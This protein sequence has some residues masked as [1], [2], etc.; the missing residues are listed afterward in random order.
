MNKVSL[1]IESEVS[2]EELEE[3]LEALKPIIKMVCPC[4]IHTDILQEE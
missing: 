3:L 1:T 4:E 2:A